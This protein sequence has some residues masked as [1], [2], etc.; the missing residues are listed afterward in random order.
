MV[1][2]LDASVY[3]EAG[4]RYQAE[5]KNETALK[6]Y[7]KAIEKQPYYYEAYFARALLFE[8]QNANNE[9][10]ADY[11][12][13]LDLNPRDIDNL[14][15]RASL[16]EKVENYYDAETD[17]NAIANIDN[18][19]IDAYRRLAALFQTTNA[20]NEKA[21]G[22]YEQL[23][24][25]DPDNP[26]WYADQA[27]L[28]ENTE[29]YLKAIENYE[30]LCQMEPATTRWY[31]EIARVYEKGDEHRK[32]I[33][34]YNKIIQMEPEV[35]NYRERIRLYKI[36]KDYRNA[37]SDCGK[38]IAISPDDP[39]MYW[40]RGDVY[41]LTGDNWNVV[42]DY[43]SAGRI[44]GSMSETHYEQWVS[45]VKKIGFNAYFDSA[46]LKG[47]QCKIVVTGNMGNTITY[48][49]F[50]GQN[51]SYE[52]ESNKTILVVPGGIEMPD[53]SGYPWRSAKK[54]LPNGNIFEMPSSSFEVIT[55]SLFER[56]SKPGSAY[57]YDIDKAGLGA[58]YNSWPYMDLSQ[59]DFL[60]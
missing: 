27:H 22:N 10:I 28:Y 32:A 40:E 33:S 35:S 6:N 43:N 24:R 44:A 37:I 45:A 56:E 18:D 23:K 17:Y 47:G 1:Y 15:K 55:I 14:F 57:Q 34:S 52:V 21:I 48:K 60:R 4:K 12:M 53:I 11:S 36:I 31:K 20:I 51:V 13:L 41:F 26:A 16:Y 3:F 42:R 25:L 58:Y 54:T 50:D 59:F 19:N 7:T 2:S 46:Q 29:Q 8:R 38:I 49:G 9:A 39:D 30:K 5:G